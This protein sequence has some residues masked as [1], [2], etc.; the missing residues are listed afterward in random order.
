MIGKSG[1]TGI[2]PALERLRVWARQ[3]PELAVE[4]AARAAE[5]VL[6]LNR[7]L[8]GAEMLGRDVRSGEVFEGVRGG[9]IDTGAYGANLLMMA[10]VILWVFA[11][12]ADKKQKDNLMKRLRGHKAPGDSAF[13]DIL[14]SELVAN[15][16]QDGSSGM[17]YE[18]SNIQGNKGKNPQK[19]NG[20]PRALFRSAAE[21]LMKFGTWGVALDMALLL[22]LR[23]E[24]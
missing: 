21:T 18:N 4:V 5:S 12:V 1:H 3:D 8:N 24:G 9:M 6:E 20:P 19:P 14:R 16:D 23:A 17:G 13:L 7:G 2:L 15:D 11:Q 22:H 10:H